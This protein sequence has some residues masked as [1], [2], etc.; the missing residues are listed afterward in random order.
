[1]GTLLTAYLLE[2]LFV[3]EEVPAVKFPYPF[4]Q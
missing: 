4:E 1:M 3:L 2:K